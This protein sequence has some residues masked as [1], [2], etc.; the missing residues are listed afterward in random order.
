MGGIKISYNVVREKAD[1][2]EERIRS[3][4]DGSILTGYQKIEEAVCQSGGTAAEAVMEDIRQEREALIE[5]RGV[6]IKILELLEDS[7]DAFE[8]A[9]R[10][11]CAS[12]E[13]KG[14]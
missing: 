10:D 11:Y 13:R 3:I 2:L 6:M 12:L 1:K 14:E 9:D 5:F 8:E 7:M 4:L